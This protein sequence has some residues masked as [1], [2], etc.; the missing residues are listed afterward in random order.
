MPD[1]G[2]KHDPHEYQAEFDPRRY[3][4]EYYA[5][6]EIG[7]EDQAISQ[8]VCHWLANNDRYFQS[9]I[10]IGSGPVIAYPFLFADRVEHL[11][12][13]DYL[14]GNLAEIRKWLTS[15]ADAF[16]WDGMLGSMLRHLTGSA[17]DMARKKQRLRTVTRDLLHVDLCRSSILDVDRKYDLVTSFHCAECVA[18]DRE[19]W[20]AMFQKILGLAKPG[21]SFFFSIMKNAVRYQILGKWFPVTPLDESAVLQ[22]LKELGIDDCEITTHACPEFED[23][24]FSEV[25]LVSG[26]VLEEALC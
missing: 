25:L 4:E 22:R 18:R 15:D 23:S 17:S 9:A 10:D 2:K 6:L 11:D 5:M 3:L 14:P 1:A 13:A 12:F 24:G 20:R 21:G 8:R 26:R 7:E 16:N 19:D